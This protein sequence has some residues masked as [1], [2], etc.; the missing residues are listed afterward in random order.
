M[1]NF[2]PT[3]YYS[4]NKAYNSMSCGGCGGNT[5]ENY[6][7]CMTCTK[8]NNV[9]SNFDAKFLNRYD[10]LAKNANTNEVSMWNAN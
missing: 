6:T 10:A 5:I 4:L 9:R 8:L 7:P 2:N 1:R 3:S